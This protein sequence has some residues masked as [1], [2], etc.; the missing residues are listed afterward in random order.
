M[1]AP[2][3]WLIRHLRSLTDV[4]VSTHDGKLLLRVAGGKTVPFVTVQA[5]RLS[6][7]DARQIQPEVFE[8]GPRRMLLVTRRLTSEARATL[9]E[10]G[11]S[12]IERDTG[13]CH[14]I[15]PG[16]LLDRFRAEHRVGGT[17]GGVADRLPATELQGKSGVFAETLLLRF[18]DV[19]FTATASA[20][21]AG[22][23]TALASRIL[24]RLD[25]EGI[26]AVH[27]SGPKKRRTV[28]DPAALLD[29]W[30]AEE[31]RDKRDHQGLYVWSR[32][33][34]DLVGQLQHLTMQGLRWAI[35]GVSAANLYAP[36]L[37]AVLP[38]EVWVDAGIPPS[39]VAAGLGGEVVE[40][41]ANVFL[42][43]T[44]G[45][46]ALRHS[47]PSQVPGFDHPIPLVSKYRAYIE[48]TGAGGRSDEVAERLRKQLNLPSAL[49]SE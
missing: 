23:S 4:D 30:S 26:T 32:T 2:E 43:Q 11:I 19:P 25:R 37:T 16:L 45:D 20:K 46:L 34:Q 35:G 21:Q 42:L 3:P 15:G 22:I 18:L 7:E 40:S 10:R 8:R 44:A 41:G 33:P 14:I 17:R 49:R 36:T 9:R 13:C 5:S 38:P 1:T 6:V 31:R 47:G 29:L 24:L 27:D 12:W 39:E 48:A 28:M